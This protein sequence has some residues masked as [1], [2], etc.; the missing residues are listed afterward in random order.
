[1]KME[2]PMK[3]KSLAMASA[4]LLSIIGAGVCGAQ[5][6]ILEVNVPFAFEVG[7]KTVPAGSYR[8]ETVPTGNGSLQTLRSNSGEARLTISTMPATTNSGTP[9]PSLVFHRYGNRCFLAQIRT[10]GG[11]VRYLYPTLQEKEL[12]RY[13]PGVE[14]AIL[15]QTPAA[16]P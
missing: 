12:A 4:V 10:G 15:V 16:K 11:H 7:N 13:E 3:T 9:S 8:V 5:T 1:M 6:R 14:V 2:D